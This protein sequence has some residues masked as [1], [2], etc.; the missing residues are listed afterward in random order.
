M[1]PDSPYKDD[2][3]EDDEEEDEALEDEMIDVA[4]QIFIRLAEDLIAQKK[5]IRDVWGDV[6]Q[7]AEIEGEVFELLTPVD[8]LDGI[9]A[10]GITDLT[11]KQVNYLLKV[12]AKPELD[13]AIFLTELNQIMENFGLFDEGK[14]G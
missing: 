9:K 3:P 13:G 1:S 11:E 7:E 4:E 8:L 10:L 2:H 12:L 14:L 5:T 6:I